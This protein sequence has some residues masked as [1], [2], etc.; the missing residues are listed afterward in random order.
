MEASKLLLLDPAQIQ[1]IL[2]MSVEKLK[3]DKSPQVDKNIAIELITLLSFGDTQ[4]A[5]NLL[6]NQE[7]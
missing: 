2:E 5:V 6:F 4:K 3:N 7:K 1:L